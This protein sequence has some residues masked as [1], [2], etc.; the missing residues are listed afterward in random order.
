MATIN[1]AFA[2]SNTSNIVYLF[3]AKVFS[4][5]PTAGDAIDT[6]LSIQ[7]ITSV[8]GSYSFLR[9]DPN[10]QYYVVSYDA[11]KNTLFNSVYAGTESALSVPAYATTDLPVLHASDKR[12]AYDLTASV[13]KVWNG[14]AWGAVAATDVD[15]AVTSLNTRTGAVI[16]AAGTNVTITESPDGTFTLASTGGGVD[17]DAFV[18]STYLDTDTALAADSDVK[19]ATQKATKA[20]VDGA[21]SDT[22]AFV[23]STYLDTDTALAADSDVKV[24]TQKATK[25]YVDGV[26]TAAATDATTKA[27]AAATAS[28]PVATTLDMIEAAADVDFDGKKIT[29]LADGT[30]ASDAATVGQLPP[31]VLNAYSHAVA[32]ITDSSVDYDMPDLS[33]AS[34]PAGTYAFFV[35]VLSST[36]KSGGFSI[37]IKDGS[38]NILWPLSAGVYPDSYTNPDTTL[39]NT[40]SGVIVLASTLTVKVMAAAV[41][42]VGNYSVGDRSLTLIKIT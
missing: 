16:L 4:S 34:V 23:P 11:S 22:D 15:V 6:T 39:E 31:A 1:G 37:R 19:V 41:Q 35:D 12:I 3:R 9:V 28:M 27:N 33:I 32:A 10:E 7:Q 26:G 30:A 8:D 21:V 2:H 25:A 14:S 36:S 18:P 29:G 5:A 42:A 40:K 38:D 20:Y 13:L 24:A 17:T